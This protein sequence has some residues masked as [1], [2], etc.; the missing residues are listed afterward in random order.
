MLTI[1]LEDLKI[2][3]GQS[4]HRGR[5]LIVTVWEENS[6]IKKKKC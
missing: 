6:L 4:N 2:P 1:L 3:F 5:K